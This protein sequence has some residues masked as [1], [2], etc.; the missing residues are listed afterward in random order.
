MTNRIP[1][2]LI[3]G[4]LA[5]FGGVG[6]ALA[7]AVGEVTV[8]KGSATRL[9]ADGTRTTLSRGAAVFEDDLLET[10][11]KSL[12]SVRFK[13]DTRFNLGPRTQFRVDRVDD[14]DDGLFS[15]E[16][17]RGAFRFVTGLISKRRPGA[18][19][20]R[21]GVVATIGIR[22]TT[23]GGEVEGE[24]A[25]IVLLESEDQ[26]PSAIEVGNDY[27]SVVIDQ[28]GYGTR[29]PD[30]HS[31]PSPPQRMQLRTI[32]NLVRNIANIQRIAVPRPGF[33]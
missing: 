9:A 23:V 16:I 21:T 18:M 17:L 24:S 12:L 7:A 14:G 29:V 4:L 28:A 2:L 13:D 15:A 19:R 6:P 30:A 10:G 33:H 11:T 27:G 1:I 3:A 5:L 25:T 31:P 20:V 32:E 22:G 26:A 8:L